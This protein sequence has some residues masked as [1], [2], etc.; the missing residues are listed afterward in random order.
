MDTHAFDAL[1]RRLANRGTRRSLASGLLIT[2][3]AAGVAAG[4]ESADAKRRKKK[5]KKKKGSGGGTTAAPAP[6]TTRQPTATTTQQPAC[7]PDCAGKNCGANDGCD[8]T[9]QSGACPTCQTC[10]QGACVVAANNTPC[11]DGSLCTTSACQEGVCSV[12][13]ELV[14]GQPSDP[15]RI[16]TCNP[17]TGDC[18]IGNRQQGAACTHTQICHVNDG[19]CD[20]QGMCVSGPVTC[21]GLQSCCPDGDY[22]GQCK[23]I[24]GRDCG[25]DDE[26][27]SGNCAQFKCTRLIIPD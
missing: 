13:I 21:S 17:A 14:C 7:Q 27:C 2:P 9:C 16:A 15:C 20:G 6:T 3:L 12:S 5:K 24:N 10:D 8:G 11:D 1:V 23:L 18:E 4:L 19:A 26:C 25:S 22:V